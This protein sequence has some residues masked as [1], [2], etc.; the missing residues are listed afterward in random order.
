LAFIR[1]FRGLN[2]GCGGAALGHPRFCSDS[3]FNTVKARSRH[4]A[5]RASTWRRHLSGS[6]RIRVGKQKATRS[7]Q[8]MSGE[9]I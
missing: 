9:L 5:L 4:G 8:A 3:R 6:L 2:F 7:V 1:V